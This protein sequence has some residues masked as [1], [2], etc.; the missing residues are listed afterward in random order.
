MDLVWRQIQIQMCSKT[1]NHRERHNLG[2]QD[3]TSLV[4]NGISLAMNN[5]GPSKNTRSSRKKFISKTKE[6]GTSNVR[7]RKTER[8]KKNQGRTDTS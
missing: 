4:Q 5:L 7:V 2:R 1:V 3:N 8:K 6:Q